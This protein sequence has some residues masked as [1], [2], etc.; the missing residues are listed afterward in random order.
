M[1]GKDVDA[2]EEGMMQD[3]EYDRLIPYI[4][5]Y[6]FETLLFSSIDGFTL[7]LDDS[8]QLSQIQTIIDTYANVE[9][10]NGGTETAPSKRL[11]H[12]FDYDKVA[13][14]EL[15]LSEL[16]IETI[17][18]KCPRFDGWIACLIDIIN[19]AA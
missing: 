7:L 1:D 13:D 8:K 10:I 12:I 11:I 5:K 4:Q 14:S 17:R 9:D 18:E 16:D 19:A 3:M 2:I 6:E 15:V